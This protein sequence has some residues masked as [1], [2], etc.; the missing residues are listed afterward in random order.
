MADDDF[1]ERATRA[2]WAAQHV[3][4][5]L[6]GVFGRASEFLWLQKAI[7]SLYFR[8]VCSLIS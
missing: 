3:S 6:I 5:W 4:V 7:S 2:S 8:A 1:D